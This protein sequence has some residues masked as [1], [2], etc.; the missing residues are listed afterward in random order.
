MVGCLS[1]L[2]KAHSSAIFFLMNI[3]L[4]VLR[5][6]LLLKVVILSGRKK[7]FTPYGSFSV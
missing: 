5:V 3:T 2:L 1:D 7:I 4:H 6:K